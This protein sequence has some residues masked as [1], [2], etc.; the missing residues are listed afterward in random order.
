MVKSSLINMALS[1]CVVL[2]LSMDTPKEIPSLKALI[3]KIDGNNRQERYNLACC[4]SDAVADLFVNSPKVIPCV[5][6]YA[7]APES[8]HFHLLPTDSYWQASLQE[9]Q[10]INALARKSE[11]RAFLAKRQQAHAHAHEEMK[12]H[13]ASPAVN[14]SRAQKKI[15]K[16]SSRQLEQEDA[17]EQSRLTLARQTRKSSHLRVLKPREKKNNCVVS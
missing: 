5:L 15:L 17:Q 8:I 3:A 13:S 1:S 4:L 6:E 11:V 2:V 14:A 9:K 10:K 12:F 7:F 16:A